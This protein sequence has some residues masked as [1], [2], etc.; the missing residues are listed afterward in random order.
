[1]YYHA[2]PR[3]AIII[4]MMIIINEAHSLIAEIDRRATLCTADPR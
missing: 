3:L 4:M 1:M 2:A